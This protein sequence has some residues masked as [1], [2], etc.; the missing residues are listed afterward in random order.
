ML[1]LPLDHDAVGAQGLKR[2]LDV[3]LVGEFGGLD[4]VHGVVADLEPLPLHAE[5]DFDASPL[6]LHILGVGLRQF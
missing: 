3:P 2:P 1:H 4:P 5:L 6:Q